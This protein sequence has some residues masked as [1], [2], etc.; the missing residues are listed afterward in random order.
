MKLRRVVISAVIL[1]VMAAIT[2]CNSTA[3]KSKENSA[4]A[5]PTV[6]KAQNKD[7]V[8]YTGQEAFNRMVGLALKWAPDAQPV[9]LESEL[10]SETNG[11]G[12]KSTI[13]RGLFASSGRRTIKTF[14]CSGSRLPSAPPFGVS[15]GSGETPYTPDVAGFAFPPFLL[16]ADSDKAFAVSQ[17]HGGESLTKKNARETINYILIK[18]KD[19]NAPSWYVIY[20]KTETDR[21]GIGVINATTGTFLRAAK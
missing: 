3:S 12:G 18:D 6:V 2:G 4:E 16:K 19:H 17:S 7:P 14:I 9:R 15:I 8:F 10:T 13:W 1:A 11:Q 20:G 21:K 5:S